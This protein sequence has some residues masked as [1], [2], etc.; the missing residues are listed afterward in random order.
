MTEL[1]NPEDMRSDEDRSGGRRPLVDPSDAVL[2]LL[3][4]GTIGLVYYAT[5][6]FDEVPA[7]LSQNITPA[8]FPRKLLALIAILVLALPFEHRFRKQGF[9]KIHKARGIAIGRRTWLTIGLVILVAVG[10]PYLGTILT[11]LAICIVMPMLW[12]ERRLWRVL[13]FSG[14]FTLAVTVLFGYVLKVYFEPGLLG[15]GLH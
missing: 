10:A 9:A 3:L 15:L 2:A 1:Q 7:I 6:T 4:L 8:A 11:M 14:V 12:G 5:T 13:V